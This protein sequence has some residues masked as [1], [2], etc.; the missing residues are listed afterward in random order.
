M[1]YLN[2]VTEIPSFHFYLIGEKL[3]KCRIFLIGNHA[4]EYRLENVVVLLRSKVLWLF[5]AFRTYEKSAG[6]L[7]SDSLRWKTTREERPI[8][9][10][11]WHV[12]C[13][14]SPFVLGPGHTLM[15]V[16]STYSKHLSTGDRDCSHYSPAQVAMGHLSTATNKKSD[17]WY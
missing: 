14:S 5:V 7:I 3:G 12:P 2:S 16:P 9:L 8:G 15:A 13:H 17:P 10:S 4:H 6:K 1:N 11:A